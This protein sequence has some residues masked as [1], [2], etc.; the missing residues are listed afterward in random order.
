MRNMQ[1]LK[2]RHDTAED[3]L[4]VVKTMKAM[5]AANIRD[6]EQAEES[7]MHYN[8]G[9]A[10]AF[11]GLLRHYRVENGVQRKHVRPMTGMVVL[12]S[13]QGMN[14]PFNDRVVSH[15]VQTLD[16]QGVDRRELLT[17]CVGQ[18]ALDRLENEGIAVQ[19][20]LPVPGS[21]ADIAPSVQ[22]V[23]TVMDRW[24]SRHAISRIMM[25]YNQHLTGATYEPCLRRLLPLDRKWLKEITSGPWPSRRVPTFRMDAGRLFSLLVRHYLFAFVFQAFAESLASENAARLAAMQGA[26]R[27]IREKIDE[28]K[29]QYQQLRQTSITEE[30]L[31]V[32]AGFNALKKGRS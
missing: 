15:A 13:D 12:G 26:E 11:R 4:S 9:I 5:A 32:V 7:L 1:I 27:N 21:P 20:Y 29:N 31:E 19:E 25:I 18:R 8:Q 30:L 23:I 16:R 22:Q 28:L 6:Y 2:K 24:D 3:L 10:L 14:G 17:L